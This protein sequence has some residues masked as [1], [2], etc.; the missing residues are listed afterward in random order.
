VLFATEVGDGW[1]VVAVHG[2]TQTHR[3]W[4]PVAERLAP[5]H[6]FTL[7]D[8]P[9]HGASAD[10]RADLWQGA[11]LLGAVGGP[12]SYVGYSMGARLC[13]HLA[14]RRPDLVS[15]VVL[16]GVHPGIVDPAARAE[17]FADDDAVARRLEA[18]GVAAFV[19]WW[20]KGPLFS[21]LPS[22][23]AGREDR[24]ANTVQGLA[25]SLRLAGT[26]SQEPL[27]GRL[28]ELAMPVLVVAGERDAKF[29]ELGRAA[30]AAIGGN[31]ELALIPGA[32]HACHLERPDAFCQLLAGFLAGH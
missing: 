1:P 31:A 11:D 26:G 2:F 17:R 15:S 18:E 9:G 24:L 7:V 19:D 28:P 8:A 21:T 32:G 30:A 20:L 3:S 13:L 6:H 5:T 22:S 27:W 10:V 14:L 16:I 29:V 4:L 25:S 12:G 23:A